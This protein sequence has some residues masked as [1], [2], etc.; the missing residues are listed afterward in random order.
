MAGCFPR[1]RKGWMVLLAACVVAAF[2][3]DR[4]IIWL[5][6]QQA[7]P[8]ITTIAAPSWPPGT[9]DSWPPPTSGSLER[10]V[11]GTVEE[12]RRESEPR[13]QRFWRTIQVRS[14]FPFQSASCVSGVYEGPAASPIDQRQRSGQYRPA[15]F[16]SI[17]DRGVQM[18][19]AYAPMPIKPIVP[20]LFGNLVVWTMVFLLVWL[21]ACLSVRRLTRRRRRARSN[22]CIGCGYDLAGLADGG[23]PECGR[24]RLA[25]EKCES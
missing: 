16:E 25:V 9:P 6:S 4:A 24:G 14:G 7:P 12:M 15:A 17:W 21:A 18:K 8:I 3:M 2:A 13:L 5:A 19:R 11:F 22:Q 20:G 1:S 23:C 10:S